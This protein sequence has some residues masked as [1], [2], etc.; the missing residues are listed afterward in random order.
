WP[1]NPLNASVDIIITGNASTIID[2]PN[3]AGSMG[4]KVIGVF[5]GLD[6]HGIPHNVT[7]TRVAYTTSVGQ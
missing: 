5:G 3:G 1:N 4:A 6:L 2:L 7:W